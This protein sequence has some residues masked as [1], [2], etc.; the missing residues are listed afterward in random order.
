MF[1]LENDLPD[2]LISTTSWNQQ[3]DIKQNLG[4]QLPLQNGML[5]PPQ[6]NP[7]LQQPIQ[8]LVVS[9][10]PLA[11]H[12]MANKHLVSSG[13]M[14]MNKPINP[15]MPSPNVLVSKTG[16]PMV[17]NMNNTGLNS[18][19]LQNSISG[20]SNVNIMMG[21]NLVNNSM[22]NPHHGIPQQQPNG[23]M[24]GRNI[25]MHQHQQQIRN[26]TPHQLHNLPINTQRLQA[27]IGAMSPVNN[28]NA[29]NQNNQ[30][31]NVVQ[32]QQPSISIVRQQVPRF[33]ANTN[34]MLVENPIPSQS[35]ANV[36]LGP[37]QINMAN[38]NVVPPQGVPAD[39]TQ[40][41][42]EKRKMITQQLVLLL[43]AHQCQRRDNQSNGEVRQCR[44]Q[45]CS[46]MKGVL[47]NMKNCLAG[48][49]CNV[50][51]CSS[52][53]QIISHWKQC[54]DLIALFVNH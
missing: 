8:R 4:P 33:N 52:S 6:N 2:E 40:A 17:V 54:T 19:Q 50:A 3:P 7:Q 23:P 32:Q 1:D 30:Q 29:Y 5:V 42:P 16:E 51:H 41:N 35:Q 20:M 26:Q 22:H 10:Q 43:H 37:Q 25:A 15:N 47:A 45:H 46:T 48:R 14:S 31:I 18:N 34:G 49:N 13:A 24:A 27:P 12:F 36:R 39:R 53:R 11:H 21:N 44:L 28:F 38:Q 9:Q